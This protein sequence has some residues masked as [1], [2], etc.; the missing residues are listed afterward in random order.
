MYFGL[1]LSNFE[2][3]SKFYAISIYDNLQV[4]KLFCLY[5]IFFNF[6]RIYSQLTILGAKFVLL[7]FF[8]LATLLF[9]SIVIVIYQ[10][11]RCYTPYGNATLH[12]LVFYKKNCFKIFILERYKD[13]MLMRVA[14]K[15][16]YKLM[17]QVFMQ[18]AEHFSTNYQA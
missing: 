13:K 8:N 15:F 6:F 3:Y 5:L 11:L 2:K 10:N 4:F 16:C 17:W 14:L 7:I 12:F 1:F 18:R 9:D